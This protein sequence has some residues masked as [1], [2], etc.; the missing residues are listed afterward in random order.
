[1]STTS[2]TAWTGVARSV[3]PRIRLTRSFDER[4]HSYLGYL[5][6]VEGVIEGESREFAVAVG[7]AAHEK[8]AFRIGDRLGGYAEPVSDPRKETADVH[9]T[10]GLK[11]IERAQRIEGDPP[12][13]HGLAPELE[14]YRARG[15]RRLSATTFET[16]CSTC[17]WGCKMAVEMI[18]DHWNPSRRRYRTE[19]FCYGPK[20]C[21]LYKAGPT[22]KVPGRHGMSYEEED[23]VD[24]EETSH[25][26][27]DD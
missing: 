15:H 26:G 1:M 24:D 11:I 12:P 10:S 5:L 9:K 16:K 6:N 18:I 3:Q 14:V 20:S 22:R 7:K 2:K 13:W 27:P 4:T 8:H 17:V 21:R 23:W 25:R 19:T